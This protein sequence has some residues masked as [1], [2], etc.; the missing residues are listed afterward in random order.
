MSLGQDK[1][2]AILPLRIR[3]IDVH[4]ASVE[5]GQNIRNRNRSANMTKSGM[6]NRPDRLF[7]DLCA[8]LLQLLEINLL[9]HAHI[10]LLLQTLPL[11]N[12]SHSCDSAF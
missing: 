3:R 12:G 11:R 9:A 10:H 1:P 5:N 4:H 6:P 2:I 7:A 8:E